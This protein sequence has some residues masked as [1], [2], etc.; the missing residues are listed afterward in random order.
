MIRLDM[1]EYMEKHNVSKLIGSPAGYIGYDE[2]GILTEAVRRKPYS[3]ILFDEVEKGHPDIYNILLQVLDDGRLTDAQ[4]REIDFRNAIIIMTSNIGSQ[5]IISNSQDDNVGLN[6]NLGSQEDEDKEKEKRDR[7]ISKTV[8]EEIKKYFRPELI[9]RVD[10]IVVFTQLSKAEVRK[11]AE[12]M[13]GSLQK[14]LSKNGLRFEYDEKTLDVVATKGY[15]PIY[16]ARPLRRAITTVLEDNIANK[17][18]EEAK[19]LKTY[20]LTS[21]I[22][23]VDAETEMRM[24]CE[25]SDFNLALYWVP[26]LE[27]ELEEESSF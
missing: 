25:D 18:L 16:G 7:V 14:R 4:G 17:I 8:N 27:S 3:I 9:N 22:E 1:S 2:G 21:T 10:H 15:D 12:L 6:V 24:S 20:K 23:W 26:K 19:D 13:L 5:A 11:I